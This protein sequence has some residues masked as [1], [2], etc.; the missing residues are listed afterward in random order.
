M[1][2]LAATVACN[3]T[4]EV[5]FECTATPTSGLGG[6]VK[7]KVCKTTLAQ[8]EMNTFRTNF[9]AQ[10]DTAMHEVSCVMR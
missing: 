5:C 4:E 2:L 1:L 10:H 6:T 9:E 7:D 8:S 3:R